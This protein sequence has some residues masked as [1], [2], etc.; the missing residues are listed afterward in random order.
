MTFLS[1]AQ[2]HEDVMLWR[3]LRDVGQG[4]YIDVGANDPEEHSV[5]KAF[6]DAGWSGINIEPAE[7]FFRR[8]EA[9][10]PR[11]LNLRAVAAEHEGTIAFF[12]VADTGL[13]TTEPEIAERHRATGH[14]IT[15][16][17]VTGT[18]LAR[19]CAEHVKGDV[20]FLKI[21]VEGG[22]AAVIK[23]M[24]LTRVR[25]WILLVEA[26]EPMTQIEA[27]EAWEGLILQHGYRFIY[28]DGLNRFYLAEEHADLAERFNY[29]P[30]VFDDIMRA[31]HHTALLH[32][33]EA[34]QRA[35]HEH[36][37]ADGQ[38]LKA[39]ELRQMGEAL[40]RES[41]ELQ[42]AL[43]VQIARNRVAE[44]RAFEAEKQAALNTMLFARLDEREALL[45]AVFESRS[46]RT[47]APLRNILRLVKGEPAPDMAPALHRPPRPTLFIEC[48][49]TYHSDL[50]TGI[51]RVV[52]N[53][54][55]NA[56]EVAERYG[57]DVVPVIWVED[58]FEFANV[59]R[60]LANKQAEPSTVPT[61]A[62]PAPQVQA[63]AL[64]WRGKARRALHPLWRGLLKLLALVFPFEAA[65][66]FI[67]APRTEF[68]LARCIY[69]PLRRLLR[70]R[71]PVAPAPMVL[72]SLDQYD[73]LDGSIFLM[74]D[75]SWGIPVWPAAHRVKEQ[76]AMVAGV[77]Y[78]LIP[79]THSYTCVPELI[80]A[81]ETWLAG[82][83]H[84]S[85]GFVCISKSIAGELA[86]YIRATSGDG[87]RVSIRH[88]H[89]G[90][91][92][93]F[94]DP[95]DRVRPTVATIFAPERHV[96]I[97]VGSIEPR[98]NHPHVLDAFDRFW[99][100][101]GTGA[102]VIIGRHGWKSDDFLERVAQHPQLGQQLFILRDAT[103]AELDHCYRHASSLVI[104]SEIEGFGLPV[105]EAFQRG[106]QV[107][108]S[109]I[110]VFREIAEGKAA[111]FGLEAPEALADALDAFCRR[112]PLDRRLERT[113]Q[114]WIG[115]RQ[116]TEQLLAAIMEIR[117]NRNAGRV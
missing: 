8:L 35:E 15:E 81:F 67:Y 57:F 77:I 13:S 79:V 115:W 106:L 52:R 56:P 90:S 55:R 65:R 82:H 12:D 21:D 109:D 51:Q 10:R 92:L 1:Y 14:S 46:W 96:F 108:C 85:D 34:E 86:D 19:I 68:G 43:S 116:S 98:K 53:V 73:R 20:H 80:S 7:S 31:S 102:L 103:D 58:R 29:P 89:L 69:L 23:G 74:L 47:T 41:E 9:A 42:A 75:S 40:R 78:D 25:P 112:V 54:L 5:T 24:D 84:E 95:S 27:Y 117:D 88:F 61:P 97:Q 3:A 60:V 91:E 71:M 44:M 93:D 64:N 59:D 70:G 76:G 18:T 30:N 2:N 37:E 62:I 111:F 4:F 110:P 48:T 22:T 83:F 32:A 17:R 38:R 16:V 26:T 94:I 33:R 36:A 107:L 114:A 6:Y 28:A 63:P 11:D 101:G 113:P 99:A 105:V 49:H 72:R 50:N 39:E 87:S 45:R 104:A 66:R 100:R